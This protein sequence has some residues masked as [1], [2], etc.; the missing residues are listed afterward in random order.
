MANILKKGSN[1]LI[2]FQFEDNE[3]DLFYPQDVI[4]GSASCNEKKYDLDVN[5]NIE[6]KSLI[7]SGNTT[8]WELGYYK[9]DVICLRNGIGSFIPPV[10]YIEFELKKSISGE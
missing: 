10:G 1:L 6:G 8:G 2:V 4:L 5:V 9:A 7:I 3:W